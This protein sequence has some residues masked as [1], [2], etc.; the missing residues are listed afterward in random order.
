M[1]C[2]CSL[3]RRETLSSGP[4]V[5]HSHKPQSFPKS[6][7]THPSLPALSFS[8]LEC[9]CPTSDSGSPFS[10]QVPPPPGSFPDFLPLPTG[11]TSIPHTLCRLLSFACLILDFGLETVSPV[12]QGL[13]Q[14]LVH[15][16]PTAYVCV[17]SPAKLGHNIS[18]S[19]PWFGL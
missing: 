16:R 17:S 6:H 4:A 2:E 7:P 11:R 18:F 10:A 3:T 8:A 14:C 5:A 13:P 15:N 12:A 19:E 9:S 1:G